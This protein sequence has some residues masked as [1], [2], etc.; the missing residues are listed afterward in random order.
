MFLLLLAL[1]IVMAHKAKRNKLF[2]CF[3]MMHTLNADLKLLSRI[4]KWNHRAANR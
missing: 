4:L 3:S 1:S 2:K